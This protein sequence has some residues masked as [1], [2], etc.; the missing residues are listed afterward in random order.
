[1]GTT[2][3][4]ITQR[5]DGLVIEIVL[6]SNQP[7]NDTAWGELYDAVC[8]RFNKLM[9]MAVEEQN[10]GEFNQSIIEGGD[11]LKVEMARR[12]IQ[13]YAI[14]LLQH[15]AGKYNTDLLPSTEDGTVLQCLVPAEKHSAKE[16]A[17]VGIVLITA[18]CPEPIGNGYMLCEEVCVVLWEV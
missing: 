10:T 13:D 4:L 16:G 2:V 14:G 1:M 18:V 3:H 15:H 5:L 12:F 9:V 7:V 8:N 17:D 6:E 11:G